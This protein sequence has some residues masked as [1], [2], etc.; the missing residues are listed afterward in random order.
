MG[1]GGISIYRVSHKKRDGGFSVPCELKVLY[2]FMSLDQTSSAEET[3][4]MI[5]KFGWVVLILCPF[6]E[7]KVIFKFRSIFATGERALCRE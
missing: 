7:K 3:D 4:T 5:I 2:L 6:L 1:G